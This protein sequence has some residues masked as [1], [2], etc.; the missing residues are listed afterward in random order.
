[1][2]ASRHRA[3]ARKAR[4]LNREL[5]ANAEFDTKHVSIQAGREWIRHGGNIE[6]YKKAWPAQTTR[7]PASGLFRTL[8]D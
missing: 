4:Q 2:S 8:L 1:M 3:K 5:T 7:T 6:T